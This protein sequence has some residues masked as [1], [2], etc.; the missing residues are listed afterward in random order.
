MVNIINSL[1]SVDVIIG[2]PPFLLSVFI[3]FFLFK[4]L[5]LTALVKKG[6]QT[7]IAKLPLI[8]LAIILLSS[9]LENSAWIYKFVRSLWFP[10]T[11]FR[12]YLFWLRLTWGLSVI[13]FQTIVLFLES[14]I[15]TTLRLRWYHYILITITSLFFLFFTG[16]AIFN[17]DCA[18]NIARP[19]IE[20]SVLKI[21]GIY[22]NA[23]LFIAGIIAL[24]QYRQKNLPRILKKQLQVLLQGII[25]PYWLCDIL[26]IY[27]LSF[28]PTWT[29]NSYTFA[30]LS[31]IILIF[32]FY[33]CARRIMGLRFLNFENHVHTKITR[34]SFMDDFKNTLEQLS[35]VNTIE[36]LRHI[37]Q[38]F[39]KEAFD[40]PLG[41]TALHIRILDAASAEL[42]QHD[43]I[44]S[45]VETFF[46]MQDQNV[47]DHIRQQKILI[48]DDITFS[49]FY[50]NH[51][52]G[53]AIVRFM[54]NLNA[55]VFLPIYEKNNLVAYIII[56]RHARF[57]QFYSSIER[58]EMLVFSSYMGNIIHLLQSKSVETLTRQTKEI[59]EE[60]YRKHQEINQ[61]KESI[62]SFLRY[63]KQQSIGI[64][65][66]KNNRFVFGNQTAKELI[67][68]NINIQLGH[69][70]SRALKNVA[71]TVEQYKTPQ[72]SFIKD[73]Q[74]NPLVL[75]AVPHLEHN[76]VIIMVHYPEISDILK[77]QLDLLH[78]PS[79]W[80][81]VLYLE[82]TESGKLI[83]QL[84]PGSG[85][86]LL[87]FKIELLKIALSRKAILLDMP[88]EDLL[89]TVELLHHTSLRDNLHT[90][91]LQHPI[92]NN[93]IAIQ[94]FGINPIFGI[95]HDKPLLEVLDK[96]GT[97][98]IKNI[99]YLDQET[100]K[101]LAEFIRYGF[102]RT[103]KSDQKIPSHVRIICSSN[104]DLQTLVQQNAFNAD[105]FN[106]L[107][108]T[109]LSMPSLVTL[110]D[111]EL[112]DLAQG[113]SDLAVKTQAFKNMLTLSERDKDKIAHM[114][115]ASLQEL[116][117]NVQNI[118]VK[119][120][121]KSNIYEE[122]GFDP[123][124]QTIDPELARVARLG[125]QALKDR[126]IMTLLWEK[127]QSQHKIAAFLGVNRSSVSR[128]FK[129]YNLE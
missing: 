23:I 99:E 79:E 112:K 122:T 22:S 15:T 103:F 98:Y 36:E 50:E 62:R 53:N 13:H 32:A 82:T 9:M 66:Y 7:N 117:T 34:F 114:R 2:S 118:L 63:K 123:A 104:R 86:A 55:D 128:R 124:Y 5:L 115:P 90:L 56:D 21:A 42:R 107:K 77:K 80:D 33:F 119:K 59:Q 26:Q 109:T 48:Y 76:Q 12:I 84:I 97:L 95:E 43:I 120:S 81:F 129:E 83:N 121:Q 100:Q 87:K 101:H 40:V 67:Q 94:L 11:D 88:E 74:G 37:T 52:A 31:N 113:F 108:Q 68:V 125:K 70:I 17:F 78:D 126:K 71:Q 41:K 47:L 28:S 49:N 6:I 24:Y 38:S 93:D 110:P 46:G 27:P 64:I 106:E 105:L 102:F 73:V 25:F 10:H 51:E 85:P 54:D 116:K 44:T 16:L 127:F 39:F 69:P 19:E 75:S 3:I 57:D 1:I 29:T 91:D 45:C 58:D 111:D 18:E 72:T 89:S 4:A 65:F 8:L 30:S 14:L 20:F 92:K 60:L 61:Y 35:Y 96:T